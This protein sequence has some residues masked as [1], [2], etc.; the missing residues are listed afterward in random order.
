MYEREVSTLEFQ[1]PSGPV[2]SLAHHLLSGSDIIYI[3]LSPPLADIV[4]FIVFP[5][6]RS[7]CFKAR[8]LGGG[9]YTLIRNASFSSPTDVGSHNLPPFRAQHS[10]WHCSP[11]QSTW[12][13]TIHT[14][15]GSV[16][17]LTLVLLSNRCGISK[18]T[19]FGTQHPS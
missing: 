17:S 7:Q 3:S 14:L 8:L 16:S 6:G 15:R 18:S 19:P 12:D 13:L 9:F 10:Y 1:S 5:F 2:S 11:I 4:L